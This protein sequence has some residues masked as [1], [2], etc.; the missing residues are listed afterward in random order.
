MSSRP[1]TGGVPGWAWAVLALAMVV[2]GVGATLLW[3]SHRNASS[4]TS[5]SSESATS[6]TS[7]VAPATPSVTVTATVT[8]PTPTTA[9]PVEGDTQGFPTS[10]GEFP[11]QSLSG[12]RSRAWIDPA[13]GFRVAVPDGMWVS[14]NGGVTTF[15]ASGAKLVAWGENSPKPKAEAEN[16]L[17][18]LGA[19][20]TL[21]KGSDDAYSISG[22][23][24]DNIFYERVLSGSR[25]S[26]WIYWEY[27][28]SAKA[29]LDGPVTRSVDGFVAGDLG[30][31]HCCT[32]RPGC[33]RS[34]R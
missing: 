5:A 26:N 29:S 13:F 28:K 19:E 1:A 6:S 8:G 18:A 25:S 31:T 10:Q 22:F 30:A 3:V 24:G 27:P 14:R 20:I 23:L 4:D 11:I 32:A 34:H 2:A 16:E 7:L 9:L 33:Q 12:M 17:R 15:R 21:S